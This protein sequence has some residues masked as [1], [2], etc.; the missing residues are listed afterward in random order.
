[1]AIT[2]TPA[3]GKILVKEAASTSP[4]PWYEPGGKIV[5]VSGQRAYFTD[6]EGAERFTHE[7]AAICDTQ[8]EAD[9]LLKWSREEKE[10][11]A[12]WMS[13]IKK[14]H[15]QLLASFG[16]GKKPAKTPPKTEA[17][18]TPRVRRSR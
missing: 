11:Y 4:Y 18:P 16:E 13:G 7:Y 15:E 1:M 8:E 3:V 12:N 14:R 2:K 10:N 5:R 6:A 17:A 9:A